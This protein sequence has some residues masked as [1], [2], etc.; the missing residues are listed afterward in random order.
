V[1]SPAHASNRSSA[2]VAC[3]AAVIPSSVCPDA[4]HSPSDINGPSTKPRQLDSV[5]KSSTK[6]DDS[7]ESAETDRH[8]GTSTSSNN[9]S[10]NSNSSQ[11]HHCSACDKILYSAADW[12]SHLG[13]NAHIKAEQ[14]HARGMLAAIQYVEKCL[15]LA[16]L[17]PS[18][19]S[20]SPAA[21]A[22]PT[23]SPLSDAF[24]DVAR[25]PALRA[26]MGGLQQHSQGLAWRSFLRAVSQGTGAVDRWARHVPRDEEYDDAT[27][28]DAY[29]PNAFYDSEGDFYDE[30]EL[31]F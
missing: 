11:R 28:D 12:Q 30:C 10:S 1:E 9:S 2:A 21:P 4:V 6:I 16:P 5:C 14:A 24:L 25:N 7:H 15:L 19:E 27:A 3:I 23:V 22:A 20:A 18:A 26:L 17:P 13:S 31:R 29:D 8:S